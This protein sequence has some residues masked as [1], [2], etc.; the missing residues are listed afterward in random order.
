MFNVLEPDFVRRQAIGTDR[1]FSMSLHNSD[2]AAEE[3]LA[4]ETGETLHRRLAAIIGGN[5]LPLGGCEAQLVLG[6]RT[7]VAILINN[8]CLHEG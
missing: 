4:I 5:D 3:S 1:Q 2:T 6:R 7:A 8:S